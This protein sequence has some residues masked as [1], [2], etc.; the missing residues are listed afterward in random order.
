MSEIWHK[1]IKQGQKNN[2]FG[3]WRSIPAGSIV[4]SHDPMAA[5]ICMANLPGRVAAAL[6]WL[7]H[8]ASARL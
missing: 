4:R 5:R 8:A 2:D 3:S 6:P 1:N 7:P